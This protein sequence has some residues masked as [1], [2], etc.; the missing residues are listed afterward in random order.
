ML[1]QDT[2]R[3][4][5]NPTNRTSID[6]FSAMYGGYLNYGSNVALMKQQNEFPAKTPTTAN[7]NDLSNID[8]LS[9]NQAANMLS[10]TPQTEI[11]V[12]QQTTSNKDT[13][14]T[15]S[16]LRKSVEKSKLI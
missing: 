13:P 1:Q 2:F 4:N 12:F 11:G 15:N 5:Q 8:Y 7:L 6:H 3:S 16:A 14:T 10:D 9:T